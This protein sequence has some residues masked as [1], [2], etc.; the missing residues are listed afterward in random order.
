MSKAIK[1]EGLESA[2][3]EILTS[4][5][6]NVTVAMKE[7]VE[8]VAKECVAEIKD[9]APKRTGEY[10]KGFKK[11]KISENAN[12]ISFSVYNKKYQITSP[13]EH[14]HAKRNGDRTR[15]FPH[16]APA[17]KHAAEKLEMKVK[18]AVEKEV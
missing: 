12:K 1:P 4:F 6:G 14:G 16:F 15:A 9:L 11:V 13:L 18:A 2:I 5:E 8:E 10:K 7:A 3:S 17:E